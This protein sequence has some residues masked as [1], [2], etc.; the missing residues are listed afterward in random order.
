MILEWPKSLDTVSIGILLL[1]KTVVAKVF[2]AVWWVSFFVIPR[3]NA[4]SFKSLLKY[5]L[6]ILGNKYS[7]SL[8][9]FSI[10]SKGSENIRGIEK[11]LSVFCLSLYIQSVPSSSFFYSDF[12]RLNISLYPKPV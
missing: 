2:L 7:L 9:Y 10:I 12:L 11:A 1:S 4:I 6:L 3:E 5:W 8:L